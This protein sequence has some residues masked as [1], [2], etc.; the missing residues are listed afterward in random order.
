MPDMLE[1]I[2]SAIQENCKITSKLIKFGQI[3][4][5]VNADDLISTLQ[6]LKDNDSCQFRQLTDIAGVDFPEREN[7]FDV[8]YHF[9]SFKHNVRIRVKT[10][11]NENKAI[12]SITQ[13]FPAANWFEREAF[14]MYGIQFTDHPDLRRILTDYGFEGYPLRKDFPLTGNVEVR[15]DEMEK[16]VIYEPVKLQQD[17]RNFDIQSP[18]EGTK[19]TKEK[20]KD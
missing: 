6:F 9:L 4:I 16:K 1:N 5:N 18:W 14:D 17:Y 7:R 8:I 11:I 15:Y 2:L 19:Y 20:D 3:Q 13:L 10:Q 12:Q